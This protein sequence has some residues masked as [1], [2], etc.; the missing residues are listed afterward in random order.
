MKI[1]RPIK[2]N[3]VTQKFGENKACIKTDVRRNIIYPT[4]V[5][6][7]R[8]KT[9]P[10]GF[11]DFYKAMG[12]TGHN[13]L[14]N[15]IYMQEPLFFPFDVDNTTWHARHEIDRDGGLGVD[16]ISDQPIEVLGTKSHI[17][18][19]FWHLDSTILHDG[20][21]VR[22]GQLI[23]FCGNSGAS[24]GPHLHW[25]MKRCFKDG[26]AMDKTNG[27][28]GAVDFAPLYEN[29]FTLDILG[30]KP[31]TLSIVQ[32]LNRIVFN[33]RLLVYKLK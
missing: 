32:Q 29:Q 26:S 27:Y 8:D 17:K 16:V 12:L 24:S 28:I 9:C 31:P 4:T 11:Q 33:L 1:Y 10:V 21:S 2:S 20:E 19:R 22:F 6:G 7:K 13:G 5:V 30:L 15:A 3:R 23:A 14:D 25:S 18:L